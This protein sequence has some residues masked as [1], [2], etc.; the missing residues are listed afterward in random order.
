VIRRIAPLALVLATACAGRTLAPSV[1][2][3]GSLHPH[4]VAD[5]P[6][7]RKP[8]PPI[9]VLV[10]RSRVRAIDL[11]HARTLWTRPLAVGGHPVAN[12]D[13]VVVPTID[14]RLVGLE[15]STGTTRFSAT[16][17]GEALT[18]LTVTPKWVVATVLGGGKGARA[19]VVAFATSDGQPRWHRRAEVRLGSPLA[20]GDVALVPIGGQIAALALATG[21][22]LARVDTPA[23][24]GPSDVPAYE[25]LLSEGTALVAA[26]GLRWTPLG[27]VGT[28]S[29]EHS[30]GRTYAPFVASRGGIDAGHGEAE[31]LRL[32]V[33]I[34]DVDATP[35]DAVLLARRAVIG[36]RLDREGRPARARWVHRETAGELVAMD[37]GAQRIVLVREDG[38]IVQLDA[39]SGR[40]VDRIAGGDR[41]RGALVLGTP[42]GSRA[43]GREVSAAEDLLALLDDRDPRLLPAQRLAA[44]LLWRDPDAVVRAHVRALAAG[45]IRGDTRADSVALRQHALELVAA[46]WGRGESGERELLLA[47][48]RARPSF[49]AGTDTGVAEAARAAI[50]SGAPDV[51]AELG[52]WL[53]HPGTAA[54]DL[55]EI[56][57]ALAELDDPSAVETVATFVQRYHAD[58]VVAYESTAL[59]LA[60]EWLADHAAAGGSEA[61]QRARDVLAALVADPLCEAQLRATISRRLQAMPAAASDRDDERSALVSARL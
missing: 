33:R 48:L 47:R 55:V 53:L 49:S 41:V 14:G 52:G 60:A 45:A 17:P 20:L 29:R 11:E 13:L 26:T 6:R 1:A 5:G 3:H 19:Q 9:V 16:L 23:S 39:V 50:G 57:R 42:S 35:R 2:A 43:P 46:P 10:E 28:A 51:V 15:R 37:V 36:L 8:A 25:T 24:G 18:G 31:R 7:V 61:A 38:A 32:W 34:G 58:T 59:V 4:T 12:D 54:S 40:V 22:E 27:A 44:D 21:R 56:M 30:L